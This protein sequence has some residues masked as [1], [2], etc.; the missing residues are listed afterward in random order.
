M[1]LVYTGIVLICIL[2]YYALPFI[3]PFSLLWPML[4]TFLLISLDLQM[5]KVAGLLLCCL[6]ER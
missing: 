4:P 6:L 2:H 5:F 1:C 3:Q